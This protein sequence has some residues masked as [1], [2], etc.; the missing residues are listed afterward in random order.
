LTKA[1]FDHKLKTKQIHNFTENQKSLYCFL[2]FCSWLLCNLA[3]FKFRPTLSYKL[4]NIWWGH[5]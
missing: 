1:T 3:Q 4:L 2:L 5:S